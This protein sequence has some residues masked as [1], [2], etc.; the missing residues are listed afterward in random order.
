MG[1]CFWDTLYIEGFSSSLSSV[2]NASYNAA[3]AKGA[4]AYQTSTGWGG[5]ASRAIDNN[6]A[7][8]W[9]S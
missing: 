8:K 3:Q 1:Q 4:V 5:V 9:N 7:S 6:I 2:S